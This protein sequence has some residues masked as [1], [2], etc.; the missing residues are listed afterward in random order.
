VTPAAVTVGVVTFNSRHVIDDTLAAIA[1]QEHRPVRVM[2]VDNASTDGTAAHVRARHPGVEVVAMP[3]NRGPNPARNHA[4]R[5]ATTDLVLLVDDDVLLEPSCLREL[6]GAMAPADAAVAAPLVVYDD[7]PD[8]V[9]YGGC[10][11]HFVGAAI[12]RHGPLAAFAP[13]REPY[14]VTAVAGAAM[15]VRRPAALHVGL[16]DETYFFGR[17][18]G[19]FC[20]RVTQAGF[21]CVQVPTAL[22]RHRVKP[23]GRA[24][25]FYQVRNRWF[26]ILKLY[27][28]RTLLLAA[29]ALAGYE[30]A[31]ATVL[32]AKG[33]FP[34]YLRAN[35]A[36]L[37]ALP[38]LLGV[39]RAV[40]ALRRRRDAEWLTAGE[41][42]PSRA[43]VERGVVRAL[44]RTAN[45]TLDAYWRAVR[46]FV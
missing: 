38:R 36:V 30:V 7:R 23:R 34:A 11:I 44:K 33:Q 1:A 10:D 39:R 14:S 9:Q 22:A 19:E 21:R 32:L 15:L 45:R 8:E 2:V 20:S 24:M 29:P 42:A 35:A 6:I 12:V 3:D 43:F 37:A 13:L 17:T 16:F 31:V 26:S 40:Q 28:P 18:D 46:R 41:I 5:E 25:V 4:L 27:S